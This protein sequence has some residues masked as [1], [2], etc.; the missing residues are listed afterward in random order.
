[1]TRKTIGSSHSAA[2]FNASCHAPV[3]TA[4]SP[5]SQSTARASSRRESSSAAPV[6]TGRC[7]P[8]IPQ[9]PRKPRPT[10]KRCIEPPRPCAQPSTRPNS[11]AITAPGSS[12]R[13]SASP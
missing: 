4:P 10:S 6:A 7:P 5:S 1:M 12:P 9:P 11:S 13:A 8:T 2:R 3:L